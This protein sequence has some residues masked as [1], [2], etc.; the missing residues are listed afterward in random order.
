M[1]ET[2]DD[3]ITELGGT[4]AVAALCGTGS[5]AVS[6]WRSAGKIPSNKFLIFEAALRDRGRVVPLSLFSFDSAEA[7]A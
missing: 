4:A 5:P 6:N 2:V 7:R 3:V 1:L